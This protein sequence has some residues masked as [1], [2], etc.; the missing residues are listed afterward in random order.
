MNITMNLTKIKA[1]LLFSSVLCINLVHAQKPN[2]ILIMAEDISTELS[3]YGHPEVKT[4]FLDQLAKDGALY[5]NAFTTAPSCTPSR[6][7]IL[8]GAY[9]TS[10][11]I[12]DQRRRG[13]ELPKGMKAFTELLRNAGYYT[14]VGCG[15]NPKTDHNF[16]ADLLYD[17][18]KEQDRYLFDSKD[19]KDRKD[20]QPFFA[21]ITLGITHRY[22]SAQ[23]PDIREQSSSPVNPAKISLPPY[24]PDH[25]VIRE[26][27]AMYL[28]A[29]EKM[30][31]QV[32]EILHRIED[33]GIAD[34]TVVIFIGDNGRCHLRGKCWLY[35]GGIKVPLII[36]QPDKPGGSIN[37]DLTSMIDLT[38]T[39]LD[40]AGAE[41]PNYLDGHSIIDSNAIFKSGHI[42]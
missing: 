29:I 27:W 30:D 17:K 32:G 42:L 34:N 22:N 35:D 8:T 28:D 6:N 39:I 1:I 5:M 9:Q 7:A 26:D 11:D 38:A 41:L 10:T 33:E 25:P 31:T 15:Y 16:V 14:A 36:Y 3:C 23:W 13:I 18:D 24:F 12:Q 4:P 20:E 21:Q 19:W 40:V 2:I 37:Q